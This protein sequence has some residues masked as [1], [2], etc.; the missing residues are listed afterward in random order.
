VT[1]PEQ[2]IDPATG[3]L[4]AL[5]GRVVTM[6]AKHRV[7]D[8]AVVYVDK[9]GIAGVLDPK[10]DPPEG[11]E[12]TKIVPT[13]GTI[14]PGLIDLHNHLSYNVL[15]LWEVPERFGNRDEWSG[16]YPAYRKLISGP[17]QV[18]GKT[19]GYVE[20]IVRYVEAKLLLGGVTTSQGIALYSNAGITRYYRGLVRNVE[21]TDEAALP[22]AGT[23]I[24]DLEA[25]QA[26]KFLERLKRST[27]LLF[28]L[29]EGVDEHAH[30][31]FDFLK[32]SSRKWALTDSLAAIHCV[33][34]KPSDYERLSDAGA[35][36][37]WSPYSNLLLYGGTA[38]VVA[39]KKHG[40][41]MGLGSDWSPSGSR[42]LLQELKVARA[43]CEHAQGSAPSSKELVDAVTRNAAEI[44]RWDAAVGSIETGKRADLLVIGGTG[45]DPYDRLID[46]METDVEMVMVNGVPRAGSAKLLKQAGLGASDLESVRIGAK[47]RSLNLK[48]K[49]ADPVVGKLT[50]AAAK[51]RLEGGM[52]KLSKLA[53]DL[54]K[55]PRMALR[56]VGAGPEQWSLVL[57]PGGSS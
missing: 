19:P 9:G 44:L 41:L 46:A 38:D 37:I 30:N 42:N 24:P 36:M 20:A 8:D 15:P 55:A 45:G 47:T 39:V 14:Y 6:N 1:P 21:Q 49:T 16:D 33:A 52:A 10:Q 3:G 27:C 31:A 17:M 22:E 12:D 57:D 7:H 25:A 26:S 40:V 32:I 29:A 5:R 54:E 23:R 43:W 18:L 53:R 28:H 11:F 50:L 56:G 2:I 13:K 34:L 48:Q 51:K 35:A 4:L